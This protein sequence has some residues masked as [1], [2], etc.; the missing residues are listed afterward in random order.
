VITAADVLR[1]PG[2]RFAGSRAR[3]GASATT[4]RAGGTKA[5]KVTAAAKAAA[6]P[7]SYNPRTGRGTGYGHRGGDKRVRALQTA[8]NRIGLLDGRGRALAVDGKLGPLTTHA[9]LTA[10]KVL[11]L[12]QDGQVTP[13]LLAQIEQLAAKRPAK[14]AAPKKTARSMMRHDHHATRKPASRPKPA[15]AITRDNASASRTRGD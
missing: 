15:P 13:Q 6:A 11:G 14:K 4:A 1:A 5:A 7:M 3:G 12:K 2:G 9:V 8:L 10:Q